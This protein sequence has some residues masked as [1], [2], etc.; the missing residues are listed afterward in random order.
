M[1]KK[2]FSIIILFFLVFLNTALI[3]VSCFSDCTYNNSYLINCFYVELVFTLLIVLFYAIYIWRK[4]SE[5]EL[6]SK[7]RFRTELV[8]TVKA[9]VRCEIKEN[10]IYRMDKDEIKKIMDKVK[11][12]IRKEDNNNVFLRTLADAIC[13]EEGKWDC[14]KI[15]KLL[16]AIKN[17]SS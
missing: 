3:I 15:E 14:K 10:S 16:T 2:I 6:K 4:E 11:D 5:C 8:D 9:T 12:E 17:I 1:S 7:E 13:S